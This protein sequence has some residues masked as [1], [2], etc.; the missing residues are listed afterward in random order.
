MNEIQKKPPTLNMRCLMH[1]IDYG[2]QPSFD[3]GVLPE[4]FVMR[5]P[6]C[7]LSEL[8]TYQRK[9]SEAISQVDGLSRAIQIKQELLT[10]ELLTPTHKTKKD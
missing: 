5:C 8:R 1:A 4:N 2:V 6:I 10:T 3:D 9:L 7:V